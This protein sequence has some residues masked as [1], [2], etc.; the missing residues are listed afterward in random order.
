MKTTEASASNQKS[1]SAPKKPVTPRDWLQSLLRSNN[2]YILL[3]ELA[4]LIF[5]SLVSPNNSFFSQSNFINI[6]W[7]TAETLLL[8]IGMTFVIIAAGIDLSVGTVLMLSGVTASWIMAQTA[9]TPDQIAH[10]QYPNAALAIFLGIAGGLLVGIG[11]GALNG[12]LVARLKLPP[13][14]VTLGT[15]GI[16]SGLA[17]LLSTVGAAGQP[18][19]PPVPTPF[20]NMLGSSNLLLGLPTLVIVAI[21]L[22]IL[23]HI[24]LRRTLFGRWTFAVGS[25][26][27]GSRLAGV[28]VTRQLIW[29]YIF[30]G[31]MSGLAGLLDLARFHV[32]DIQGHSLDNLSAIAAVVIGGTS[33]FG[34]SGSI[35]GTV[36]GAFLPVT[37]SYGFNIMGISSFWQLVA[38]GVIIIAAVLIDQ[39]RRQRSA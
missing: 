38:V 3:V 26:L 30:A 35:I 29:V 6:A 10:G 4:L 23:G 24:I 15:F 34:G 39:T 32:T 20:S 17:D 14:I 27:E 19:I 16:T 11:V 22:A 36:I 7:D 1:A 13:F 8:G 37:L 33:L 9:G 18:T 31:F 25:N 5:F 28:P 2:L 21:V 12:V